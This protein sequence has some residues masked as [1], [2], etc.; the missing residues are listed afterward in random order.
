MDVK[1]S[2]TKKKDIIKIDFH[3]TFECEEKKQL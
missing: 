1:P 3:L 2:K